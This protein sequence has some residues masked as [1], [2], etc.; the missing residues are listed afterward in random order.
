MKHLFIKIKRW[1]IW[2]KKWK[3]SRDGLKRLLENIIWFDQNEQD[4]RFYKLTAYILKYWT[5]TVRLIVLSPYL[6]FFIRNSSFC[7]NQCK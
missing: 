7:N 2:T 6:T 5:V 1:M 3:L 4:T